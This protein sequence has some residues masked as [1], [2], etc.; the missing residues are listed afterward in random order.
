MITSIVEQYIVE[1]KLLAGKANV[2]VAVSGGADS[3]ALLDI[4]YKLGYRCI[5]AHCNFHLRGEESNRDAKFV[6]DI[7]EQYHIESNCIDFDT[8]AY[9]KE[10]SISIEMAA[11]EL[12]YAWF[13]KLRISK[14]V[15]TIAVA[16]H[17]DDSVETVLLNL[18]RGTG[19]K[20][21]TGISPQNG[22]IIR[23]L[24]PIS[25]KDIMLYIAAHNLS[26]ITDSTNAENIY[27]RNKI[28]LEILPLLETINPSVKDS[29]YKTSKHLLQAERIYTSYIEIAKRSIIDSNG[30]NIEK[31]RQQQEPEAI[32]F[33]ILSEYNFNADTIQNIFHSLNS[34]SGKIFLSV[35]H[36]VLKDRDYLIIKKN[37]VI[38]SANTRYEINEDDS[39]I[40]SPIPLKIE[41]LKL[42]DKFRIEK[43]KNILYLDKLSV[44]YPLIIRRW[45][46][47]DWFIPFGMRG[48][49]KVSDYFSDQ[50]FNLF[51]KENTWLLCSGDNIIWI[52]GHRA[53][54]RYKITPSTDE[55]IKISVI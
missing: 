18:I 26:F 15:D 49:K 55:V 28:R 42:T 21:L 37:D 39:D 16:H 25:R 54:D 40:S 33:E 20:G 6:K 11:R 51:D 44:T 3:V 2:I 27:T 41:L 52:I 17:K 50:K 8:E 10:K 24:L 23:P 43:D 4:L 22:H 34:I 38:I 19:I 9:A 29:I 5:V 13:E 30:I 31:L 35:T 12:R 45:Q 36:Q 46:Q 1:N 32:L 47:G 7:C 14:N 48:K 53:D